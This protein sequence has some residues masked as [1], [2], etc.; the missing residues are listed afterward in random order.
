MAVILDT[1]ALSDM[2]DGNPSL[3]TLLSQHSQLAI[4]AIVLGEYRYGI[5]RSHSRAERERWLAKLEREIEVLDVTRETARHYADVRESLRLA[6]A[7]IPENDLWIAALAREHGSALVTRDT[8]FDR[9]D[10]IR[11]LGW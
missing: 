6:G 3:M 8:H 7:P 11:R 4:P 9:V 10:G 1:N 5:K 2:M